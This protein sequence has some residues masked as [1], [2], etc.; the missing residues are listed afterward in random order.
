MQKYIDCIGYKMVRDLSCATPN[1]I[2]SLHLIINKIN[3]YI[4]ESNENKYLTL[5]P[6][7]ESKDTLKRYEELW[8]KLR[9]LLRSITNRLHNRLHN[10]SDN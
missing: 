6:T 4:E 8:S 10:D 7:D 2:K 5:V 9:D 1:S 3:G